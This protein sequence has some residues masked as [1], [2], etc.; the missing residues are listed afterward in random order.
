MWESMGV[1]C[2]AFLL[3]AAEVIPQEKVLRSLRLFGEQ[4]MPKFDHVETTGTF[5]TPVHASGN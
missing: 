4:V 1:D 3:N 5:K 2:V